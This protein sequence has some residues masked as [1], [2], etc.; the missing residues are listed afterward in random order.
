MIRRTV[1]LLAWTTAGVVVVVGAAGGL[2][3]WRLA[4]GPVALDPLTPYVERALSDPQGRYRV[5][6][7]Q[8]VLSWVDEEESDGLTRL[9]LRAIDVHAV[10][11]EGDELAAVP[12]LGV[13]FSVRALFQGKLSPTRLDLVRPRLQVVRRA[14]GSLDFDVRSI[15]SPG[16]PEKDEPEGGPDFA[17]EIV[18]TLMQP[19]D[20]ARPLGLLRRLSIIG[21]DLTVTNRMLGLSW[22]ANRA[23]IVLTRDGTE[24]VGG[25]QLLL[26]LDGRTAAVEASGVHR[27][28][29]A[30]TALSTRF[31]GLQP[32]AL[33]KIGPLLAP[34]SAVT[35]PLGGRIDATLDS[36]FEPVRFSFDLQGG[37]GEVSLPALRPDPYR[38]DRVR[39]RG[40]LDVPGR[41]AELERLDLALDGM[42]M[43][44]RGDLRE[45]G[46]QRSGTLRLD[47]MADGKRASLDL[48]GTQVPDKGASVAA[49]LDG[50]VPATLAGLA[51]ALAPL[52]AAQLPLSGTA[53]VELD[54][55]AQPRSG[56]VELKAGAGRV[57]RPDLFPE[58]LP[59]A[60]AALTVAGDRSSGKLDVEQLAIDLGGPTVEGTAQ[61]TIAQLG[62]P[63]ARLSVEAA[64]TAKRVPADELPRLWPLGV[65]KNPREWVT[66]NLSHGVVPEATAT[67]RASGPLSDLAALDVTHFQAGIKA[68][69]M[70]V[71]YF[72]PLP[73]VTGLGAEVS[74][75]G[76]TFTIHTKGGRIDDVQLGE[77]TIVIGGLDTGKE[78]M[79]IRVPV[80]GPVRT[81]LTVLDSPP[82]GY[83]SRLDLDPKRT[84]GQADAQLHFQFPLLVD[85]KVEQLNLD[86]VAKLRGVGVEKVAAGLTAT[87]GDLTLALDMNAMTVKGNTKLD[88]IPVTIDWKEQFTSTAK[89]PRTR[90]AVKGDVDAQDLRSHGIDLAE[91][92]EGPL[93][94][95][96]LFTVDQRRRFG[97]TAGLNLEKTHLRIDELG[98]EKKP[99]VPGT[100][101]LALEFQKD[102]VTRITGLSVDAG[103]LRAQAVV[104]LAP[105]TMAVTKVAVSQMSVGQTDLKADVTVHDG[106]KSGYSGTITGQSLDA[107]VLA[108]KADPPGG[109]KQG[110]SDEKPL[111]LDFDLKLNR[112][113]FGDGRHL[114]DVAGRIRRDRLSWTALDVTA[115][116]GRDGAVSLRYLPGAQGFYDVAISASDAGA[117]FRALDINDRVQGGVL[118]ITG[119]TV[120]PRADAAIEG[121]M[122]LTDYALVDAPVLA[123]ILN[124][125]SPSGFAELMGGGKGI[126][127]GR[128]VSDYRKDGR[129]LTVKDLRTSGSALG[130]TLSGEVDIETDTANLRGTI[131]PIYGLN[132]L[133][134]QIPLLGDALSGGEGQGIFS[135]TWH[136]R[137]PLADP[138]V[139][140][141]PLAML[142]PGFLRNLFFLGEGGDGKEAP[143]PGTFVK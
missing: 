124:S 5:D 143:S 123:R 42:A 106:G 128:A 109:K 82:L 8:L 41:R 11:A 97:L 88:G 80:R 111:P 55:D 114:S 22:H 76:K 39:L 61:A 24:I 115:K 117:T 49:R 28:A 74:T 133:I 67:V 56:R 62:T 86:V 13:G 120:E 100:G 70:T 101:K 129:L 65:G 113:V 137:G 36:R 142:A 18:S 77:G 126:R 138:D 98:W 59:I 25:A 89:G 12:E 64:V 3:A 9:D 2:F 52:A 10:N 91:H 31:D 116:A 23:D 14:D 68:E 7:G 45:R 84:Q 33:A 29:D 69:D 19:P 15:P 93:G 48:D 136:V 112:V 37:A 79:D 90:I 118:A 73:K 110:P 66:Q 96:V 26:D 130:L 38:I 71:D 47:L 85:L 44:G 34:L 108:G 83:P 35:V 50:L 119:R 102:R 107:R 1:K 104:D 6:V 75:D 32:A 92:V 139:T 4:Q 121:R 72:H 135:A 95:D 58:P 27:M 99:G 81:I 131:V 40:G 53:S 122:E 17:G 60:S 46:G 94:A 16:E 54:P 127:F 30:E 43:A 21:A 51:P 20:I 140:V 87:E 57:V 125:I 141:N 105:Q 132:R 134:G 63:D 103:G 78:T